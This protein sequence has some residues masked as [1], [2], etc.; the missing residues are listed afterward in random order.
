MILAAMI[1]VACVVFAMQVLK[2]PEL[3]A[4]VRKIQAKVPTALGGV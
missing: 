4:W 2:R 3:A 1:A